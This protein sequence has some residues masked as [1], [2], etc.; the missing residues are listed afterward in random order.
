MGKTSRTTS[1]SGS[2]ERGVRWMLHEVVGTQDTGGERP[3]DLRI[4]MHQHRY[5]D[6][7]R[8]AADVI[9]TTTD[10]GNRLGSFLVKPPPAP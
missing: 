2:V 1:W 4:L 9:W 8:P 10:V 7:R 6:A 5:R 3:E